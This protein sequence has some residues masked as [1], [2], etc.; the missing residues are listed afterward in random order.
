[1]TTSPAASLTA[2]LLAPKGDAHPSRGLARP[3]R[4]RISIAASDDD[5]LRSGRTRAHRDIFGPPMTP[6]SAD[7]KRISLRLDER[8]RLRLRLASAHLSKSRQ[9]ILLEALDYYIGNV[10]PGLLGHTCPCLTRGITT[11]N[12]C[13]A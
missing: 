6:P 10:V 12:D 3:I 7:R 1:M 2:A 8:Q 13:C 5:P 11:G 4:E 9:V